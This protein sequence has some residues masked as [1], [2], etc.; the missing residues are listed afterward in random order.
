MTTKSAAF[1]ADLISLKLTDVMLELYPLIARHWGDP[2]VAQLKPDDSWVTAVDKH[3]E[4]ELV[5]L[6]SKLLPEAYFLGEETHP[7]TPGS[8]QQLL[9]HEYVIVV[10]PIDGT[11]EYISGRKEFGSLIGICQRQAD[12]FAPI[13]GFAYRPILSDSLDSR[14]RGQIVFTDARGVSQID[15]SLD[16]NQEIVKTSHTLNHNQSQLAA[17]T[18][19]VSPQATLALLPAE[20]IRLASSASVV[21]LLQPSLSSAE[22][23][24]SKSR[25]WDIAGPIAIARALNYP[26]WSLTSRAQLESFTVADFVQDQPE[27]KWQLKEPLVIGTRW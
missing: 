21:D 11:R 26:V 24:V 22:A 7:Q 3:V 2:S 10:D 1:D 12:T 6:F 19:I 8:E 23:A 15:L 9:N 27:Y 17:T 18:R 20:C 25:F 13:Y 4:A 14:S 5:T 16:A